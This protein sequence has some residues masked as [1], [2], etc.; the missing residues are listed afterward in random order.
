MRRK[1]EREAQ[2]PQGRG[3]KGGGVDYLA[4][5]GQG[6]MFDWDIINSVYVYKKG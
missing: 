1:K 4:G 5:R 2:T 3:K 6:S